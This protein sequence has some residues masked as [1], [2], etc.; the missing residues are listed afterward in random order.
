MSEKDWRNNCTGKSVLKYHELLGEGKTPHIVWVWSA[1]HAYV[2]A[3]EDFSPTI[4]CHDGNPIVTSELVQKILDYR[5]D[6]DCD[7]GRIRDFWYR[8]LMVKMGEKPY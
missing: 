1:D 6:D 2:I 8:S 5:R 7:E 4:Y 3:E